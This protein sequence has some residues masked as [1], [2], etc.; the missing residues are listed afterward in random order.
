MTARPAPAAPERATPLRPALVLIGVLLIATNLRAAITTLGP[1]L[2][3]VQADQGLSS[4]AASVLVSV[5]LIAF[6]VCSPIAPKVAAKLGLE[7]ALGA[8]V[9]LLAIGILLRSTPPQLLL[10]TGTVLLGA[11]IAILNV[12]LP[13]F[14][15]RD[16][17]T[18]IGPI[19][20]TYTA[21][22]SGVA[23]VAAGVAVPLAGQQAGGW[24]L[25][26][27]V[28][29]GLALI[30]LGVFLPQLRRSAAA[31]ALAPTTGAA[32]PWTNALAWQVTLFM[33]LQSLAFYVLVTWLS[34]IEHA[35]GISSVTAGF[36]QLLFNLSG[37]AGSLFCSALIHR[38]PDQRAVA[39]TGSLLLTTA[40]TGLLVAPG[41]AVL[42]AVF[43][44]LAG[45]STLALALSLFGLRTKNYSDAGALSGMAQSAGYTLAALGPIAIGAIHDA[46][47]SWT[48]A[49]CVLIGLALVQAVFGG[50]ASRPKTIA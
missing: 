11:A 10:W 6:A 17:P 33:G 20:G 45:G 48:P 24:R 44:G 40:L 34:S 14:V 12:L 32:R 3:L 37:L 47:S 42:W 9:A 8:A 26:L 31:P 23:A 43:A 1:I 25:S 36:H 2:S 15:K 5:P 30:A 18:R 22:Q 27:G 21:V 13:A 39:I 7:R 38:L 29:A 19:T 4:V 50:L 49:L 46:T 28:W 35:A 41:I 16:F